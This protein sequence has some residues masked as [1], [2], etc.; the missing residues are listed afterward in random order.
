MPI[1]HLYVFLGEVSAQV[2][3]P[4]FNWTVWGI[5]VLCCMSSSYFLNINPLS[6]ISLVSIFSHS[7]DCFFI[8]LVVSCV[9]QKHFNLIVPFVHFILASLAQGDISTKIFLREMLKSLLPVFSSRSFMVLISHL[10]LQSILSLCLDI[11]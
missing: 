9:V 7:V 3:H 5:L 6:G 11:V 10:C 1:G 4:F 8:L 2:L